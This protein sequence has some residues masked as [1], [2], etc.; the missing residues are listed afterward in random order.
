LPRCNLSNTIL[1]RR[2]SGT[3]LGI[4]MH[5]SFRIPDMFAGIFTL[6]LVG[7]IINFAFLKIEQH[8]LRWHGAS[9]ET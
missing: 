4:G 8:F 2:A 6:G 9:V 1:I 5:R 3:D 7:F